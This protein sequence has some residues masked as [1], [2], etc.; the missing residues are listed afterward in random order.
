MTS[1]IAVY[2]GNSISDAKMIAVSGSHSLVAYV[3]SEMMSDEFCWND[4]SDDPSLSAL[5]QGR[6][7]ALRLVQEE[8]KQQNDQE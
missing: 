1:F 6:W 7:D 4:A 5:N 2:R 3:A 8:A